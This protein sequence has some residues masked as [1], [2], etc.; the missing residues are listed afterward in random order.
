MLANIFDWLI[1]NKEWLFS[2]I[3]ISVIAVLFAHGK[4]I[5]N[6]FVFSHKHKSSIF[7]EYYLVFYET[8]FNKLDVKNYATWTYYMALDGYLLLS[9]L[10][11][12]IC[13]KS[14]I[15]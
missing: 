9:N 3:G 14:K 10:N 12:R 13:M 5:Y 15:C 4:Q 11:M 8:V 1:K 7:K 6:R 2:G